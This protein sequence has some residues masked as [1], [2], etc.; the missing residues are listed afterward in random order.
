MSAFLVVY[1]ILCFLVDLPHRVKVVR[2]S[3]FC[4]DITKSKC[5]NKTRLEQDSRAY[6]EEENR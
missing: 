6:M 2:G 1:L 3:C 5:G 4:L